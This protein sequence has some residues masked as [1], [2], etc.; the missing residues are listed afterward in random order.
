MGLSSVPQ[1]VKVLCL[2]QDRALR[3]DPYNV[4]YHGVD[5]GVRVQHLSRKQVLSIVYRLTQNV[6]IKMRE[7]PLKSR[8]LCDR[9]T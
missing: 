3:Q 8:F 7:R 9:I 5:L 2:K 6:S 4:T 1:L